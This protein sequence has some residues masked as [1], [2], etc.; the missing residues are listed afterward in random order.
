MDASK[1][2]KKPSKTSIAL[3]NATPKLTASLVRKTNKTKQTIKQKNTTN[4]TKPNTNKPQKKT[5][6]PPKHQ[7]GLI[8]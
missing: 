7:I 1:I 2:I 8:F 4:N 6:P 3:W 5:Q